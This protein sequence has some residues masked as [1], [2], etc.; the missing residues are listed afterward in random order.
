MVA[1]L[2]GIVG[3]RWVCF[4]FAMGLGYVGVSCCIASVDC[5]E[6]CSWFCVI[7]LCG[8]KEEGLR[9]AVRGSLAA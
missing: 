7:L 9:R 2:V 8:V 1:R 6:R 3:R 5:E 4:A